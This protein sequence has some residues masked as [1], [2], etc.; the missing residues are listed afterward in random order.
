MLLTIFR[1][2][3]L[4]IALT[5]ILSIAHHNVTNV[6]DS[7]RIIEVEGVVTKAIWRN[8]H[9]QVSLLVTNENGQEEVWNTA[10]EAMSN[11]R[12]WNIDGEFI[13]PGDKVRLAGRPAH[14]G[15]GMYIS[16]V[17][18]PAGIEVILD[19][20]NFESRWSE[21]TITIAESRKAEIGNPNFPELGIF[22]VWSH[23]DTLPLLF[24]EDAM[25]NF[26][27]TQYPLT[28]S[29]IAA[30]AAYDK[31]R[32]NP[33]GNC[34]AKGMPTIMEAPYPNLYVQDGEN[35]LWHQEEQDTIR[36]IHMAPDASAEGKPANKLGYSIGH[37]Q[38]D[39]TLI[40]TT[41]DATWKRYNTQGIPLTEDAVMLE[42]FVVAEDGSRLDYSI[43][44]TD[45]STFTRPHTATTYWL[46]Y[47]DAE[48]GRYECLPEAEN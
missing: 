8:P 35:I 30:V 38:D 28:E 3:I 25:A 20:R 29:T 40:V 26:D 16:H 15:N 41:T 43:N 32:D 4:G 5:P 9:I 6:Y 22:R 21:N 31:A 24:P 45:P 44:V 18:T 42:R 7:S 46:Y 12:R 1:V 34:Q 27:F 33:I 47:A 17:L 39:H 11:L 48:V 37:W 13:K 36:T 10:S 2:F 23:P 14:Q 19:R